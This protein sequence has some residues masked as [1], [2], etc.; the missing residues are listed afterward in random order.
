MKKL[1][2]LG[3]GLNT[4]DGDTLNTISKYINE[5]SNDLYLRAGWNLNATA[6]ILNEANDIYAHESH[7]L[8]K[9]NR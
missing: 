6:K 4:K 2:S 9:K 3:T 1:I 7:I 5:M 8:T